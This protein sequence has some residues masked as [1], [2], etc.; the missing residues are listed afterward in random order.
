LGLLIVDMSAVKLSGEAKQN[1]VL[2]PECGQP[3]V[4]S[5]VLLVEQDNG[6]LGLPEH[7]EEV[8]E[9]VSTGTLQS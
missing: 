9:A 2:P 4:A 3:I 1:I 7:F 5:E 8:T 6:V